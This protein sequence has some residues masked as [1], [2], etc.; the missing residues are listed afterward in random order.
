MQSYTDLTPRGHQRSRK[1]PHTWGLLQ[2]PPPAAI[3]AFGQADGRR[4]VSAGRAFGDEPAGR[5]HLGAMVRLLA[6]LIWF[7][8]NSA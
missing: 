1:R 6:K 7:G 2:R 3:S 8:R 5:W 4:S